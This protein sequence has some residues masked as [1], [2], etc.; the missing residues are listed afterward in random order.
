[1]NTNAGAVANAGMLCAS[2]AK[3]KHA[4][5][6]TATKTY[7]TVDNDNSRVLVGGAESYEPRCTEHWSRK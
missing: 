7:R 3:N 1:M 2:G 4:A 6:K 5:N